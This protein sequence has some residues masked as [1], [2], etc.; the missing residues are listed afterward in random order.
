MVYS[1][2]I[3]TNITIN[4]ILNI[5]FIYQNH[6]AIVSF[7]I[8]TISMACCVLLN[9]T[10]IMVHCNGVIVNK[11]NFFYGLIRIFLY[12]QVIKLIVV[13]LG[14]CLGWKRARSN[15][16]LWYFVYVLFVHLHIFTPFSLM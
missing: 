11:F 1:I 9:H 2:V 5:L 6:H 12:F 7:S 8:S 10:I 15:I 4:I 13:F 3:C 14:C 16:F